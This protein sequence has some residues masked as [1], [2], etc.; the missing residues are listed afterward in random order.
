MTCVSQYTGVSQRTRKCT[1]NC[2]NCE[3]D[4]EAPNEED[5]FINSIEDPDERAELKWQNIC[6]GCRQVLIETT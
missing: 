4:T 3:T 2:C 6:G 1:F 5:K